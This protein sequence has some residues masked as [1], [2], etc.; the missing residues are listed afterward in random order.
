MYRAAV[1][2]V[3]DRVS[4]GERPDEGGGKKRETSAQKEDADHHAHRREE[5]K[6]PALRDLREKHDQKRREDEIFGNERNGVHA[7]ARERD[8]KARELRGG[9]EDADQYQFSSGP[10]S[11]KT[12]FHEIP[13]TGGW[14]PR[15][16]PARAPPRIRLEDSERGLRPR[17]NARRASF[18]R[19]P[20]DPRLPWRDARP[21]GV[22]LRGRASPS[23]DAR[24][25]PYGL[26]RA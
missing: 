11:G 12:F 8:E 24:N 7:A 21:S 16:T 22:P 25:A 4:R 3:S 1:L 13:A 26:R 23:A 15:G 20:R 14:D 2:T 19:V 9:R 18:G 6:R 5:K 17:S 10:M